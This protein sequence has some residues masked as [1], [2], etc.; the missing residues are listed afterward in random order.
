[1]LLAIGLPHETAHGSLRITLGDQNTEEDADAILAVLPGIVER[2][3]G[4]SP[5]WEKIRAGDT[6]AVK[7]IK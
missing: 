6:T 7:M 4:M 1:M 3:R 5:L 2:L